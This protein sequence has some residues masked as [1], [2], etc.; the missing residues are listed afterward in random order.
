MVKGGG[1]G[2]SSQGGSSRHSNVKAAM[3]LNMGQIKPTL[4]AGS[5]ADT[6]S[7][8]GTLHGP[9]SVDYAPMI[10]DLERGRAYFLR[11]VTDTY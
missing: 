9:S 11:Q 7:T 5:I 10:A 2:G 3:A 6:G 1:G 8:T 4:S